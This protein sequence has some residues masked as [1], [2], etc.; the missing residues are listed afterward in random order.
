MQPPNILSCHNSR[1]K[2]RGRKSSLLHHPHHLH[3]VCI[4]PR[5]IFSFPSP[6]NLS[7]G[8]HQMWC[9]WA[10]CQ[11]M[12][13][14]CSCHGDDPGLMR[15]PEWSH[16]L[17]LTQCCRSHHRAAPLRRALLF[18]EE[19]SHCV[20][21][22]HST[23]LRKEC[24]NPLAFKNPTSFKTAALV[25]HRCSNRVNGQCL[26][27]FLNFLPQF[28]PSHLLTQL[29]EMCIITFSALKRCW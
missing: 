13:H 5:V 8:Q 9:S 12:A 11:L 21:G 18:P 10:P 23:G 15:S 7:H 25:S 26:L 1:Q 22:P 3:R 4:F 16:V 29:A 24:G 28:S 20:E 27:H 2:T 19:W 14:N 6:A 17:A